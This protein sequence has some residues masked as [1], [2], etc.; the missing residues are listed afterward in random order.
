MFSTYSV[1]AAE[2]NAIRPFRINVPPEALADLRRRLTATRW[3]DQEALQNSDPAPAG[4]SA[5]RAR[6]GVQI[7]AVVRRS[8][9]FGEN[10]KISPAAAI[11]TESGTHTSFASLKQ[12]KAGVLT[13][14][15]AEAGSRSLLSE[16]G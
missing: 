5:G 3:P 4:L 8:T 11:V 12:I 7:A 13:I 9:G 2:R 16:A 15:Y 10:G 14:G 1:A 6:T